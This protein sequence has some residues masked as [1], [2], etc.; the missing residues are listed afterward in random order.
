MLVFTRLQARPWA[1]RAGDALRAAG[2]GVAVGSSGAEARAL[3][4][5]TPQ[6]L[7]VARL[8]SRGARNH[9][10]AASLFLSTKTI[11]SHLSSV[12]RKVGVRSRTELTARFAELG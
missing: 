10:A 2:G 4:R 12:Y 7:A 1:A 8:V 9:E 3:A 6:E 5:L 11:E